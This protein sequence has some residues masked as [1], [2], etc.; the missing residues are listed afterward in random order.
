MKAIEIKGASFQ[1][2]GSAQPAL[3]DVSLEIEKGEFV[4]LTGPTGSG[5]STLLRIINGL[6]PHF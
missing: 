5:K 3:W 2:T 4:L 1:Y 6:V